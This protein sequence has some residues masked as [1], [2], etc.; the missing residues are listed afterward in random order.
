MKDKGEAMEMGGG[1][2]G[3][4]AGGMGM[5]AGECTITFRGPVFRYVFSISF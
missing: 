3:V 5:G 4:K 1:M 2:D